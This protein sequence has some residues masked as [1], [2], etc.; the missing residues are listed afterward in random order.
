MKPK[1]FLVIFLLLFPLLL[2]GIMMPVQ[3]S[4]AVQ[5]QFPSPT[6]GPDGRILYIVQ[7]G[8]LFSHRSAVW[9]HSR[10]IAQAE[11]PVG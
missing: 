4:P 8:Q 9:H 11:P 7:A 10:R 6:P 1:Q 3:A 2:F 5:E